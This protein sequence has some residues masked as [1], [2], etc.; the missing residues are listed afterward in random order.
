MKGESES[1]FVLASSNSWPKGSE[2]D[3][4]IDNRSFAWNDLGHDS[5]Y[6]RNFSANRLVNE[7]G[8]RVQCKTYVM[9]SYLPTC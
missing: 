5:L 8:T 4:S 9:N 3:L 1:T 2:D 7:V 6:L